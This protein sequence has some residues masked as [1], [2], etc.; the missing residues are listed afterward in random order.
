MTLT[1]LYGKLGLF[2]DTRALL[3]LNKP[4]LER[5]DLCFISGKDYRVWTDEFYKD[6]IDTLSKRLELNAQSNLLEVGSAAGLLAPGL[7]GNVASYTGVDLSPYCVALGNRL[8][9]PNVQFTQ[10][11]GTNL[12]YMDGHFDSVLCYDV[13]TNISDQ[14]ALRLLVVEIARVTKPGGFFMI[15]SVFDITRQNEYPQRVQEITASLPAYI[16]DPDITSRRW[17]PRR[18][19]LLLSLQKRLNIQ[20]EA[21]MIQ[22]H[23]QDRRFFE[24]LAEELNADLA[25]LP[26]HPL[27]PYQGFRFDMVYHKGKP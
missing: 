26:P 2:F 18:Y 22:N 27:N 1:D 19:R 3:F 24:H 8:G 11:D 16:D 4:T 23:Y 9:L 15:G 7:S 10:A 6:L 21:P 17:M 14:E 13:V 5:R 20:Q 25:V 12:P